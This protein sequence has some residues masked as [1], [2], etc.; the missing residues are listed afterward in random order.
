MSANP[1][2]VVGVDG[3][4]SSACAVRWAAETAARHHAPLVLLSA[5]TIPATYGGMGGIGLPQSFYDDQEA[6][7]ARTL[8]EATVIAH[9]AASGE[10]LSVIPERAMTPA[11]EA[12]VNRSKDARMVNAT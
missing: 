9:E 12:L 4:P 6:D 3:S 11:V 10:E 7:S 5:L 2:I 8:R 1:G